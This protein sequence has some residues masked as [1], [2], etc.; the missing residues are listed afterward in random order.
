MFKTVRFH[1][2]L[3]IILFVWLIHL[4]L[5]VTECDSSFRDQDSKIDTQQNQLSLEK[6]WGIKIVAIRLSAKGYMLD[7]RYKVIDPKKSLPIFDPKIN[8]Y[9]IDQ[10]SGA[11]CFVPS[12][13]KT[14]SLRQKT[15][16]PEANRD[17]FILFAN[18]GRLVKAGNKVTLVIGDFKAENL[19][20]E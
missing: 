3:L 19:T 10:A 13:P 16:N 4:L 20:V 2:W 1:R 8:P 12:A 9:I 15:R 5:S 14:G 7:F 6:K 18:P 17:Y 11:K